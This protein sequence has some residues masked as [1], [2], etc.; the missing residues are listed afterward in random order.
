VPISSGPCR[1]G[2]VRKS[3]RLR[4]L[5][6][7]AFKD[8]GLWRS[9]IYALKQRVIA[10]VAAGVIRPSFDSDTTSRQ[11]SRRCDSSRRRT[12]FHLPS[13]RGLRLTNLPI[14]S[15]GKSPINSRLDLAEAAHLEASSL[16]I[17]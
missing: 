3:P 7:A 9:R 14:V 4:R 11:L 6:H 8:A 15:V 17:E 10:S 16:L 1:E 2:Q 13:R 5:R 12:A